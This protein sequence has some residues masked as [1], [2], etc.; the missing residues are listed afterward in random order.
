MSSFP[1]WIYIEILCPIGYGRLEESILDLFRITLQ[2]I[3]W[4]NL[5]SMR[6]LLLWATPTVGILWI[7]KLR[8]PCTNVVIRAMNISCFQSSMELSMRCTLVKLDLLPFSLV[9]HSGL[10]QL[11]KLELAQNHI[12]TSKKVSIHFL[13]SGFFIS[14]WFKNTL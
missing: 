7:L 4:G 13:K 3:L 2:S 9:L 14:F 10:W 8:M 12:Q 6:S 11:Q 5:D 1:I